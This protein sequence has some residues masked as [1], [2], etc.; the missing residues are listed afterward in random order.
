MTDEKKIEAIAKDLI[1]Y[2][3]PDEYVDIHNKWCENTSNRD[4][5]IYEMFQFNNVMD[6]QP[7]I[8]IANHICNG[9]FHTTDEYFYF[10]LGNL[11]S[12]NDPSLT[13]KCCRADEIAKYCVMRDC[14][15]GYG[16]IRETLEEDED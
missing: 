4:K 11:Y 13:E 2:A 16:F 10:Y 5:F 1:E 15:L 7:P 3:N 14:D 6:G 12:T 9:D 8:Y